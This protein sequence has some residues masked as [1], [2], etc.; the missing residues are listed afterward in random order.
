NTSICKG[1]VELTTDGAI[2]V[3]RNM[4]TSAPGIFA[5]G[6]CTDKTLRQVITACGDG[7]TAAHAAQLFIEEVKG[8]AYG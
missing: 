3:D 1:V 4:R 2:I 5:C 7:A 8:E 6:D